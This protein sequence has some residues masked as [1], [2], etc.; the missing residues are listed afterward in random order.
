MT[1]DEESGWFAFTPDALDDLP[2]DKRVL[3][4]RAVEEY[5]SRRV[6]GTAEV[7]VLGWDRGQCEVRWGGETCVDV[8]EQRR[9][10]D[11]AIA[12]LEDTKAALHEG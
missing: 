7:I 11:T 3:A 5:R 1:A 2:P 9:L 6:L 8:S 4:E 10:L 12:A